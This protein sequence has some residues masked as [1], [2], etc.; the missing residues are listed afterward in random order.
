MR[1]AH[2][3]C[4]HPE[5]VPQLV[6]GLTF[7][8][9]SSSTHPVEEL[10]LVLLFISPQGD[11]AHISSQAQKLFAPVPVIG[12]TTAGEISE[13]GYG[14]GGIVAVGFPKSHFIARCTLQVPRDSKSQ[15]LL[16][17]STAIDGISEKFPAQGCRRGPMWGRGVP[18]QAQHNV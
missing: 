15:F 9:P 8:A 14:K 16:G 1:T 11:I 7:H 2:V 17:Q 12:C 10:E 6:H 5:A 18:N 13:E 4:R 3:D